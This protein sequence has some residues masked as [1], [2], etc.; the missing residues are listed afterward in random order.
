MKYLAIIIFLSSCAHTTPHKEVIQTSL[1]KPTIMK[2]IFFDGCLNG[3]VLGLMSSG[4]Q[5]E[6]ISQAGVTKICTEMA[7]EK[8]K[9]I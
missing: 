8:L 4:I 5:F 9:S 2:Q 1:L 3:V 6:K 7:D